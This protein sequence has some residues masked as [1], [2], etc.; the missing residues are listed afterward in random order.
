MNESR[1]LYFWV[2]NL[3]FTRTRFF[4]FYYESG[5]N[6]SLAIFGGGKSR[7]FGSVGSLFCHICIPPGSTSGC[8]HPKSQRWP[9]T[10]PQEH[11]QPILIFLGW[12]VFRRQLTPK[13]GIRAQA[14]LR[15]ASSRVK[16]DIG[17]RVV[18]PY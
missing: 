10:N 8:F 15:G 9:V 18:R 11:S 3:F 5:S 14:G 12:R 7:P 13:T 16:V 17:I 2:K 1:Q 6:E 4:L